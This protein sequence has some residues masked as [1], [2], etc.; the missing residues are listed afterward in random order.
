MCSRRRERHDPDAEMAKLLGAVEAQGHGPSSWATTASLTPSGPGVPSKPWPAVT[1]VASLPSAD[2]PPAG[3]SRAQRPRPA[4]RRG[5]AHGRGLVPIE[6]PGPH[7]SH[8]GPALLEMVRA[9]AY[10]VGEGK[11]ALL[12]AYHRDA[13]DRLNGAAGLVWAE[14][15]HLSGPELEAEGGRRYRA[16]R[17]VTLSPGP[18]GAWVTSQRAVVSLVDLV[19]GSLVAVTPE[20]TKLHMGPGDIG[21]AKLAHA[22]SVTAHRFQGQTVDTTHALEDGGGR[23][24]AYVAMSRARGESHVHVVAPD[25]R[26]AVR[27][28][29]WSWG[30][31]RRQRWAHAQLSP[32]ERLARLYYERQELRGS[33]PPDRLAEL[34]QA[35]RQLLGVQQDT[36]DL[37][38]GTGRWTRTIPGAAARDLHDTAVSYQRVSQQLESGDLGPWGRH[39][40][41]RQVREGST[42]FDSA[43]QA[44]EQLGQPYADQLEATRGQVAQWVAELEQA[45]KDREAFLAKH[46]DVPRRRPSS[47]GP[48]STNRNSNAGRAT[49][50]SC[51]GSRPATWAFGERRTPA[52]ASTLDAQPAALCE[53][54]RTGCAHGLRRPATTSASGASGFPT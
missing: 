50:T 43:K 6:R 28:L 29:A 33:L 44:W 15:G 16:G 41:R 10:D 8:P 36:A 2:R 35:R 51:S 12:V 1:P 7:G 26:Q 34:D 14:L 19:T 18:G 13:V 25:I 32:E 5:S 39:K 21:A 53:R 42:R 38:A 23:E 31:E 45:Q 54:T 17:V 3:P 20:G 49:S 48:S 9:W 30:Q 52:S 27:R 4:A 22:Y 46:S 47:A 11:D 37:H 24:L 40:A